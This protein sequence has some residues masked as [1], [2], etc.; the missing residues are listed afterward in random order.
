MA[1]DLPPATRDA[2]AEDALAALCLRCGAGRRL[3]LARCAHCGHAP[4]DERD[5]AAH[6]LVLDLPVPERMELADRLRAGGHFE[7]DPVQL[8]ATV[9]A[10]RQATPLAVAGYAL[11]VGGL[12]FLLVVLLLAVLAWVLVP[13]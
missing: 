8:D 5:R 2:P 1:A 4:E 11:L 12:P 9:E 10:L 3:A 6:L 13:L 7:P